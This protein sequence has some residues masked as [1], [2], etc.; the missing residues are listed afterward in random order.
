MIQASSSLF[1]EICFYK[2]VIQHRSFIL[3]VQLF[4]LSL[5]SHLVGKWHKRL[6]QENKEVDTWLAFNYDIKYTLIGVNLA[7]I[8]GGPKSEH[9]WYNRVHSERP[10]G[11]GHGRGVDWVQSQTLSRLSRVGYEECRAW[12]AEFSEKNLRDKWKKTL[13]DWNVDGLISLTSQAQVAKLLERLE[14]SCLPK[15]T[16]TYILDIY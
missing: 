7:K 9:L 3:C 10:C 2:D 8:L 4:V 16:P 13:I 5:S 12:K 15:F 14:P 11:G 6:F 1:T